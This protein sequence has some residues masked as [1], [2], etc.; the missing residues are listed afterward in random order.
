MSLISTSYLL[1]ADGNFPTHPKAIACLQKAETIVCCDGAA[2]K[3]LDFGREPD[4]IVGD[5]DSVTQSLQHRFHNRLIHIPD[6]ETNDLT[7]GFRFCL[8]QGATHITILGATGLRE[9]HTLGNIS[10]LMDYAQLLPSVNMMT[11][12]GTFIVLHHSGEIESYVGQQISLFSIKPTL[13][14][15]STNLKYPLI[16]LPLANWWQGTLNESLSTHFCLN[17]S[18]GSILVFQCY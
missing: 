8:K 5:F 10:L 1:L 4:F 18:Q 9:D 13:R 16:D 7:K 15:T 14:I 2:Q 11:D 6:Q 3:L 17:F 12:F